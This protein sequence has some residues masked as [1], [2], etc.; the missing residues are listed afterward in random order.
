LKSIGDA[1]VATDDDGRIT[2]MNSL[3]ERLTGWVSQEALGQTLKEVV[4]F[5]HD[6]T[7]QPVE[8]PRDQALQDSTPSSGILLIARDRSEKSIE[9]CVSLITDEQGLV[10]GRVVVF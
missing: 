2:Y 8:A 5:V 10:L 6:D 4:Q 1:V 9:T 7:R 3:A